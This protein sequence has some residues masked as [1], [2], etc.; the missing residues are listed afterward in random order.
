MA[1]MHESKTTFTL[2]MRTRI[3]PTFTFNSR[4]NGQRIPTIRISTVQLGK[5]DSTRKTE[6]LGTRTFERTTTKS[7]TASIEFTITK[8]R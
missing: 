7:Y 8:F 5:N 1:R 2:P 3:I 4:N 6:N